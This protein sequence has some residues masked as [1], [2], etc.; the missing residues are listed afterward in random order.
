MCSLSQACDLQTIQ[1]LY[2]DL[3]SLFSLCRHQISMISKRVSSVQ[4]SHSVMSD[5]L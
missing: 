1:N 4:F 3:I 5:S 2:L